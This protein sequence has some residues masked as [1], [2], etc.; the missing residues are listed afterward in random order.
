[1]GFR[2]VTSCLIGNSSS[3]CECYQHYVF[4]PALRSMR[5]GNLAVVIVR[6]V[7]GR[8]IAVV[9]DCQTHKP[10]IPRMYPLIQ[11]QSSSY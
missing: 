3:L 1:M 10:A 4:S 2:A 8:S 7:T 5:C 11:S 6:L 9:R